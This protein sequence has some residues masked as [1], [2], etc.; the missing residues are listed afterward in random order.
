MIIIIG[1]D[2]CLNTLRQQAKC[3]VEQVISALSRRKNNRRQ[4]RG[5]T[6]LWESENSS[7]MPN[8][9]FIPLSGVT[10]LLDRSLR[11]LTD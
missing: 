10:P 2:Y 6:D 8:L 5:M 4:T 9:F 1:D 11:C 7:F 3:A